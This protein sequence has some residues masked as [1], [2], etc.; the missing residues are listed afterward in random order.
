MGNQQ[1]AL[2]SQITFV[3]PRISVHSWAYPINPMHGNIAVADQKYQ[4]NLHVYH[5]VKNMNSFL[6]KIIVTDIDNQWIKGSKDI[7][8][9]YA[10]TLFVELME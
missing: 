5:L 10:K 3:P 8:I 6:K 2:H 4:N 7:V 9:G 1:Y